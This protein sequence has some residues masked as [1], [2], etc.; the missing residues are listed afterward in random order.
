MGSYFVRRFLAEGHTVKGYDPHRVRHPRG[1]TLENSSGDAVKD[2]GV[3]LLCV[4]IGD[5]VKVARKVLPLMKK[6]ATIVEIATVKSRIRNGMESA[7]KG[8]SV[9]LLSVHPMFGPSSSSPHP[10]IVVLGGRREVKA[11]RIVFHFA[12][13][14]PMN[15]QEHDR[16]VAYSISLVH[17]INLAFMASLSNGIGTKNFVEGAPPLGAYQLEMAKAVLSQNPSLY[18]YIDRQNPF[19]VEVIRSMIKELQAL[20]KVLSRSSPQEFERL[21]SSLSSEFARS[22]L[23]S[24]LKRIYSVSD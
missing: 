24:A 18:S 10:K 23:D 19:V 20:E 16:F 12:K 1:L 14:I 9:S 17:L 21:F 5:T 13:L 22:D 8:T 15:P 4:P 11:S 3:V 6:G 2:A 7:M